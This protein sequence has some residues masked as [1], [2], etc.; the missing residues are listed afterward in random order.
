MDWDDLNSEKSYSPMLAYARSKLANILFTNELEKRLKSTG[1]STFAV[2][3]GAVRT[4]ITRME[5]DGVYKLMA[6]AAKVFFPVWYILSKSAKQGAQTSIHCAISYEA[7]Q[8]SG[9]Y[10]SD[11]QVKTPSIY[12][13][14]KNDAELLWKISEK[15]VNL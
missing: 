5:A 3:P 11:C 13:R 12:A 2:H 8:Y 4:E 1:V 10:F 15:M 6:I 9:C 7:L 14:N